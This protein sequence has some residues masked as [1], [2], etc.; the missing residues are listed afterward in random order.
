VVFLADGVL[1]GSLL[2]PT[3]EQVA[4]RLTHLGARAARAREAAGVGR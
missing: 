4:D 1:A 3:A 2:A